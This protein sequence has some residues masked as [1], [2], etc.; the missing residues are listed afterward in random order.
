MGV[1][2]DRFGPEYV[3]KKRKD[4]N[5]FPMCAGTHLSVSPSVS[6]LLLLFLAVI[7]T[8]HRFGPGASAPPPLALPPSLP[9]FL[10]AEFD[11]HLHRTS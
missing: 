11:L 1:F 6:H 10:P 4:E 5:I 7:V 3:W 2:M 8:D 9:L